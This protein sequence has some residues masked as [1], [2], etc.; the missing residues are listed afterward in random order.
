VKKYKLQI[1]IYSICSFLFLSQNLYSQSDYQI[2]QDFKTKYDSLNS[3]AD[4]I[5]VLE[6]ILKLEGSVNNFKQEYLPHQSLIDNAFYPLTL[7]S[8]FSDIET[9]LSNAL[10]SAQRVRSLSTEVESLVQEKD[11]L[12]KRVELLVA[13]VKK[14]NDYLNNLIQ[15]NSRLAAELKELKGNPPEDKRARDSL[16]IL[17]KRMKEN[18]LERDVLVKSM[19]DSLFQSTR[20]RVSSLSEVEKKNLASNIESIDMIDNVKKLILDNIE[21]LEEL[22]LE[23]TDITEL[24]NEYLKFQDTWEKIGNDVSK[25][26]SGKK[27]YKDELAEINILIFEWGATIDLVIWKEVV[28]IFHAKK[29]NIESFSSAEG[30]QNSLIDYID[31]QIRLIEDEAEVLHYN[32]FSYFED[33]WD[34]EFI[35]I[36]YPYLVENNLITEEEKDEVENKI[37]NWQKIVKESSP[38]WIYV[39]IV[40]VLLVI[41]VAVWNFLNKRSKFK[42]E[43]EI[44]TSEEAESIDETKS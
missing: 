27:K 34:D 21:F 23:Q 17:V 20:H 38:W 12:S 29:I 42:T 36:W 16:E 41:I 30:F 7:K 37:D 6:Q 11:I 25:V 10:I 43:D 4:T 3:I 15:R 24:K 1:L 22:T 5:Q 33:V 44:E 13:E 39:V 19:L 14:Q 32:S 18:L 28:E 26:Y 35:P 9:K 31:G 40:L 8:M 2:T